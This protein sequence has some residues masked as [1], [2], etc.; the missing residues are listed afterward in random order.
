MHATHL[1]RSDDT[2]SSPRTRGPSGFRR[3]TLDSRVR[4]NDSKFAAPVVPAHAETQWL[5]SHDAGWPFL[6]TSPLARLVFRLRGN[7]EN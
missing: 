6:E 7:D 1:G 2:P 4:G 5:S 3:T